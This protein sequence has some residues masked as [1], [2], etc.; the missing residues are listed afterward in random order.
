MKKLFFNVVWTKVMKQLTTLF[1]TNNLLHGLYMAVLGAVGGT[2]KP[3]ILAAFQGQHIPDW[4][5]IA[6]SALQV[7]A[8]AAGL[9]L[10]KTQIFGGGGQAVT[11]T[12][13]NLIT[14][15]SASK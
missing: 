10:S 2:L 7:A 5:T 6:L 14:T 1:A 13:Q 4:K 3:I 8:G 11:P 9:Y 15:N 12:T